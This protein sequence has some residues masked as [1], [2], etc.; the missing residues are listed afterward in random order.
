M[1][2]FLALLVVF[3]P[4]SARLILP[5]QY[6]YQEGA[7][8][9]LPNFIVPESGCNW[10]GVAGQ[11][12]DLTGEPVAGLF[13]KI[14]G[15]LEG[16]PVEIYT[17]SGMGEQIGPGGFEVTLA[18]HLVTAGADMRIQLLDISAEPI[19]PALALPLQANCN[20]NLTLVNFIFVDLESEIFFPVVFE[21]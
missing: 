4:V 18:D 2:M 16:Q 21:R 13:V 20:Q 5:P 1:K 14:F 17:L 7:P 15:N 11:V 3:M 10:A 6:L 12:F 19:S 8:V 9:F